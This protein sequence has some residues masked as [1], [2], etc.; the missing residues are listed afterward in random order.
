MAA[1]QL[2]LTGLIG[3]IVGPL[4]VALLTDILFQDEARLNW[5]LAIASPILT[6]IGAAA[7]WAARRRYRQLSSAPREVP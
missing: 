4:S 6:V 2:L 1:W 3:M 5:S 7:L